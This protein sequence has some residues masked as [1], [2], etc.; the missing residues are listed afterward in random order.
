MKLAYTAGPYRSKLGPYGIKQNIDRAEVVAG[1]LWAMGFSVICP[2][3]NTAFFDGLA[4]D[5]IWLDGD[6]VMLERCDLVV[7]LPDWEKSVGARAELEHAVAHNIP[8]YYW[9]EDRRLLEL[10][11]KAA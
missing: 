2:H 4:P 8:V 1:E 3:K 10:L 7:M 11:A 6:L 5:H 9:P